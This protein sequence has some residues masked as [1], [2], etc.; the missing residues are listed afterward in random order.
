M[1]IIDLLESEGT[2]SAFATRRKVSGDS[3]SEFGKYL[4]RAQAHGRIERLG[5]GLFSTV[6][7]GGSG[8]AIKK[9]NRYKVDKFF[10]QTGSNYK[11]RDGYLNFVDELMR[12]NWTQRIIFMK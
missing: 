10:T 3:A 7:K 1:K 8:V 6:Y 12:E 11:F 5:G 2:W 9:S 4:E